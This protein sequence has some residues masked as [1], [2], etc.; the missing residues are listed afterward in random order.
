M[1]NIRK[2]V[3]VLDMILVIMTGSW[4]LFGLSR[5][6]DSIEL[7]YNYIYVFV[8]IISLILNITLIYQHEET[9]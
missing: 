1:D 5:G 3:I 7:I 4:V 9:D 8:A 2:S 6:I